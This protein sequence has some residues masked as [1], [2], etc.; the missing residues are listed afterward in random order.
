MSRVQWKKIFWVSI[1]L[2]IVSIISIMEMLN[3]FW[4]DRSL[5]EE[6]LLTVIVP[7]SV[8]FGI[9]LKAFLGDDKDD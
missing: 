8:V 5:L 9:Y 4:P 6:L 7:G 1:P 3:I 2:Y